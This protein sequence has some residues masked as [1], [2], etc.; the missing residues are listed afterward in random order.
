MDQIA[1]AL[2]GVALVISAV[3]VPMAF[4]G[5]SI[6]VV[7]RQFSITLTASMLVHAGC[8]D[9]IPALCATLLGPHRTKRRC[10][11]TL[12]LNA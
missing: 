12:D 11:S 5:G 7:F 2:V 9:F 10:T 3:F 4:L 8:P 1:G 6:G